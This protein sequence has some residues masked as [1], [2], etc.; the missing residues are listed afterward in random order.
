[1][2]EEEEAAAMGVCCLTSLP[3]MQC[4]PCLEE[5]EAALAL[6]VEACSLN[7]CSSIC[8]AP[9][10]QGDPPPLGASA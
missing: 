5:E 7:S 8:T 4:T 2:E 6:S 10:K 9:L 3:C 1:M